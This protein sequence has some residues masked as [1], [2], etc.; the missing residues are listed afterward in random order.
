LSI[1]IR[2]GGSRQKAIAQATQAILSKTRGLLWEM[3][4]ERT[5]DDQRRNR[6][7]PRVIKRKLSKWK[8]KRLEHRHLRPLKKTF[9]ESV[10]MLR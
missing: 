7:N 8:K 1:S 9:P 5:D 2:A 3:Q 4:L 10:V 6:I